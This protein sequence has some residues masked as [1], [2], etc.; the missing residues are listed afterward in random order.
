VG[1]FLAALGP[2]TLG[3]LT[4][5]VFADAPGLWPMRYAGLALCAVFL[6]GLAA[7]PFAPE[8]KNAGLPEG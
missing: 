3:L 5:K 7:L 6:V 2:L 4:S 1:R 8:T